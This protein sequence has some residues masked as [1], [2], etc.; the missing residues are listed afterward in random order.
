MCKAKIDENKKRWKLRRKKKKK[1]RFV[2]SIL[3]QGREP[4]TSITIRDGG[5]VAEGTEPDPVLLTGRLGAN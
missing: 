4:F 3:I 2:P 1:E 5:M